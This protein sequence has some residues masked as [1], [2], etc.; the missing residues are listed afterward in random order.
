MKLDDN[1]AYIVHRADSNYDIIQVMELDR[2]YLLLSAERKKCT[3][4]ILTVDK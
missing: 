4:F 1:R 3:E 2:D